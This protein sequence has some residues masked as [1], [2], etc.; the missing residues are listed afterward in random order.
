[1]KVFVKKVFLLSFPAI[2]VALIVT[3]ITMRFLGLAIIS[4]QNEYNRIQPEDQDAIRIL[5]VGESTTSDLFAE[6][7]QGAWPR[8]L[9]ALLNKKGKKFRVYNVGRPSITTAD[10]LLELPDFLKQYKPHIVI[11]MMG[12]NDPEELS[13]K[14]VDSFFSTLKVIKLFKWAQKRISQNPPSFGAVNMNKKYTFSDE[15]VALILKSDVSTIKNVITLKTAQFTNIERA[16]YLSDLGFLIYPDYGQ[17]VE[18]EKK[19]LALFQW[20]LEEFFA[21]EKTFLEYVYLMHRLGMHDNCVSII[22]KYLNNGG[23]LND[24]FMLSARSCVIS[25]KAGADELL[26]LINSKNSNFTTQW[27]SYP[28]QGTQE[29]YQDFYKILKKNKVHLIAMQYPNREVD[30]IKQLFLSQAHDIIFLSNKENFQQALKKNKWE[31][32][33]TDRFGF[34]TGHTTDKGHALIATK[35]CEGIKQVLKNQ[36]IDCA[37][38]VSSAYN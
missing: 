7:K 24:I 36:A 10:I 19:V 29:N 23:Q 20:S 27:S 15:F 4:N 21:D 26:Q 30:E 12:I 16:K 11:S 13:L 33:F 6:T 28:G 8:Q 5:A 2:L 38:L 31:V 35:A 1:M 9:E 18:V 34:D 3:E 14:P 22:K 37:S 25:N 32:L 17:N